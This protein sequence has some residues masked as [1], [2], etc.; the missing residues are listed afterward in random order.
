MLRFIVKVGHKDGREETTRAKLHVEALIPPPGAIHQ[1]SKL[2]L[3]P[4]L[5][6]ELSI[7]LSSPSRLRLGRLPVACA[8]RR[9]WKYGLPFG[10][11]KEIRD[12]HD[13]TKRQAHRGRRLHAR[14]Q[15]VPAQENHLRGF[16]GSG[17]PAAVGARCGGA[18]ALRRHKSV[19]RRCAGGSP[20]DRRDAVAAALDVH[21]AGSGASTPALCTGPGTIAARSPA[22]G[23]SA[24]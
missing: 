24:P 4:Y 18:H 13:L 2:A 8:S 10:L 14:D 22:L 6:C 7:Y 15:H 19:D 5:G 12:R 1:V 16:R 21:H 20:A 9:R 23:A 11:C 17:R 3:C